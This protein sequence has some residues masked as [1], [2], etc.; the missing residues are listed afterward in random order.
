MT[1]RPHDGGILPRR[2]AGVGRWVG[3][4]PKDG[5]LV[6]CEDCA[7]GGSGEKVLDW[8]R[9]ILITDSG[10]GLRI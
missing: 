5:L 10:G 1:R 9:D 6:A 2:L 8:I 4:R 3:E 7:Q